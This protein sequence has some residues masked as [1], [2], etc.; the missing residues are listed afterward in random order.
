MKRDLQIKI[1]VGEFLPAGYPAFA[2]DLIIDFVSKRTSQTPFSLGM[3]ERSLWTN[4]IAENRARH[5]S[6]HVSMRE[7]V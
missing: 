4:Q 3:L 1:R 2:G 7:D 6:M 5:R